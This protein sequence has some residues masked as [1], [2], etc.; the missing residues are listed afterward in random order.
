M[1]AR[2]DTSGLYESP[3]E[4]F[5]KDYAKH[6]AE[7]KTENYEKH[8]ITSLCASCSFGFVISSRADERNNPPFLEIRCTAPWLKAPEYRHN[9]T[10]CNGFVPGEF[11]M[12][13]FGFTKALPKKEDKAEEDDRLSLLE[14]ELDELEAE[15]TDLQKSFPPD[16]DEA[17]ETAEK[18]KNGEADPTKPPSG[19]PEKDEDEDEVAEE[20]AEEAEKTEDDEEKPKK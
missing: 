15:D 20:E 9:I 12:G 6:E 16:A 19:E 11:D 17:K 14:R 5:R 1:P 10:N 18:K 8:S 13:R 2:L 4:T 7:E 3:V